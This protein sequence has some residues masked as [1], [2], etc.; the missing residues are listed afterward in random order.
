MSV[1]PMEAKS[2]LAHGFGFQ[3]AHGRVELSEII[4]AH[5]TRFARQ[6]SLGGA[7]GRTSRA[8]T[9]GAQIREAVV[10]AMSVLPF[11]ID[12]G[13]GGDLHLHRLGL[14]AWRHVRNCTHQLRKN[15]CRA[16]A[17]LSGFNREF[18]T[19]GLGHGH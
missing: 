10:A 19:H 18:Q 6:P 5:R 3:G 12:T 16:K 17:L 2:I 9:D 7:P 13:A 15:D 8:R 11:D 14:G 4:E 1:V